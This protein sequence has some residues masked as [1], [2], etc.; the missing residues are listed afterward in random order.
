ME[1]ITVGQTVSVSLRIRLGISIKNLVDECQSSAKIEAA[2]ISFDPHERFLI[3][4]SG[5]HLGVYLEMDIQPRDVL[6]AYFFAVFYLQERAQI[7]DKYWE[8][9]NKWQEF[10]TLAQK[11]GG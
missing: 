6:K 7:K 9:Q 8:L 3:A 5:H 11:E 1:R 4:E 2:L 10:S